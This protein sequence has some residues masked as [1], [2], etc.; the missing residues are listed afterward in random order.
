MGLGGIVV[1]AKAKRLDLAWHGTVPAAIDR[2]AA[3][4]RRAGIDVRISA[5]A[6]TRSALPACTTPLRTGGGSLLLNY[7]SS[8]THH[9]NY[10]GMCTS[11]FGVTGLNGA[12][13]YIMFAN[14]CGPGKW[15]TG[16]VGTSDGAI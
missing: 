2:E 14:H 10:G 8:A 9:E 11:G 7:A 4:A 6:H 16:F 13:T 5:A 1:D 12:A 3:D 15:R